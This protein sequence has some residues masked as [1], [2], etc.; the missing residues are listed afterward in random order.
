MTRER[1]TEERDGRTGKFHFRQAPDGEE[2]RGYVMTG[3]YPDGR[4][5]EVFIV[6]DRAGSTLR[7]FCDAA[8]TMTS[9]RLQRGETIEEIAQ[10]MLRTNFTPNGPTGNKLIPY[11]T[12]VLDFVFRWLLLWHGVEKRDPFA[13]PEAGARP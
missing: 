12:S 6:L 11:A 3:T 2:V 13:R 8:A 1:L 5:G 9:I 7:G 4:L 10:K